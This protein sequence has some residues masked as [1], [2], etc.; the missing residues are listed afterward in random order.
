LAIDPLAGRCLSA[1]FG[2]LQQQQ[3]QD[4]D[5][6]LRIEGQI[7]GADILQVVRTGAFF[8]PS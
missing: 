2:S 4:I 8:S 1:P 3:Q 6:K 5:N 7:K